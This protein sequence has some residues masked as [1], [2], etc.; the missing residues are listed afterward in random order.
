[1]RQFAWVMAMIPGIALA[2]D[3]QPMQGA[4][5][6]EALTGRV[7]VYENGAEQAFHASGQTRYT[8]REDSRG[9]WEVRGDQYCSQWPPAEAWACYDMVRDGRVIRFVGTRGDVT[10]GTYAA[11]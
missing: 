8:A 10:D 1:M 5:I 11:E 4:D 2:E 3:W 9:V 7:L 6:A